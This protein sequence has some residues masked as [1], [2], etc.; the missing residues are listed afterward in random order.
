MK[1]ASGH[2]IH[3]TDGDTVPLLVRL[4]MLTDGGEVAVGDAAQVELLVGAAGAMQAIPGVARGDGQGVFLFPVSSL[5]AGAGRW[6]FAIR[7]AEAAGAA[8]L[9]RGTI[10]TAPLL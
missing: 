5:P 3:R 10:L 9:A 4:A 1:S 8:V 6:P 2:T 7:V